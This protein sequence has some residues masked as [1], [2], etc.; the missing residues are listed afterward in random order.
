MKKKLVSADNVTEFLGA[1]AKEFFVDGSII[2]TSGAKDVL[3]SKG[4]KVV[5]D[6]RPAENDVECS[7]KTFRSEDIKTVVSKIVS[8]LRNDFQVT[9]AGK[10]E[11]VTRKVLSSLQR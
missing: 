6:K 9:D 7:N 2:L 10:V 4:I 8:I 1:G 3:R 11:R 5:Y